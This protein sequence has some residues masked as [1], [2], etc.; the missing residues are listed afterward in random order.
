MEFSPVLEIH[1]LLQR[2]CQ[3]SR[4]T[5]RHE[6]G[7]ELRL[8]CLDDGEHSGDTTEMKQATA[9]GGDVLVVVGLQAEKVAE[10]VIASAEPLRC[11]EAFEAAHTSDAAFHTA[12]ILFQSI[13]L[14]SAGPM[15]NPPA[16]R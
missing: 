10:F 1:G 7:G 3:R 15:E 6:L 14:V 5:W 2:F 12:M 9:V 13:V 16:E 8:R 11:I 4:Q